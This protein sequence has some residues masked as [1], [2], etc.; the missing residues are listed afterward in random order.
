MIEYVPSSCRSSF[1]TLWLQL[2]AQPEGA[3]VIIEL[4]VSDHGPEV[5][6]R[7]PAI[8]Q[9]HHEAGPKIKIVP[10]GH[11]V[12]E[13]ELGWSARNVLSATQVLREL[14][15]DKPLG[16]GKFMDV[17]RIDLMD[18]DTESGTKGGCPLKPEDALQR[19]DPLNVVLEFESRATSFSVITNL[20][21]AVVHPR[22]W[23][24]G[25]S[26]NGMVIPGHES[27]GED[28]AIRIAGCEAAWVSE[29]VVVIVLI[30]NSGTDS[31]NNQIIVARVATGHLHESSVRRQIGGEQEA[32]IGIR[33]EIATVVP[34]IAIRV[35]VA[36]GETG[37]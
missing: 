9:D 30:K 22:A 4:F 10:N 32:A 17:V 29:Y 26:A 6:E 37:D 33:A 1:L 2:D 7:L 31:P 36:Q 35:G 24:N 14:N 8:R 23:A 20:G 5:H 25:E 12:L 21:I 19:I 18:K 28:V 3:G 16:V 27:E 13:R 11:I 34:E 15:M